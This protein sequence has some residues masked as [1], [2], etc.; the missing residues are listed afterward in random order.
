MKIQ[1]IDGI[2]TG[3][4]INLELEIKIETCKACRHFGGMRNSHIDC[5]QRQR[6]VEENYG[7]N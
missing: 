4:P 1:F 5:F 7:R 2:T 3:C 6:L